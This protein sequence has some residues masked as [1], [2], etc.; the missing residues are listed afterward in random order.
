MRVQDPEWYHI[1]LTF[2][3]VNLLS[4][5][6]DIVLKLVYAVTFVSE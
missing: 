3:W 5:Q 6:I 2:S 4:K 1:Y